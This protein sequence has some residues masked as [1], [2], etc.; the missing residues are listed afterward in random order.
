MSAALPPLAGTP[1]STVWRVTAG[2]A[3]IEDQDT[4]FDAALEATFLL[5]DGATKVTIERIDLSNA[6]L[7]HSAD[8][9]ASQTQK[10]TNEH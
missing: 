3:K 8:S 7:R 1:C 4:P 6:D 2:N 10:T 9:A 5:E